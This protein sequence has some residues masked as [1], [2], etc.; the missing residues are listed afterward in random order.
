MIQEDDEYSDEN[1]FEVE[2]SNRPYDKDPVGYLNKF[3][4]KFIAQKGSEYT[5]TIFGNICRSLYIPESEYAEFIN[6]YKRATRHATFNFTEK[7]K[8]VGPLLIDI[9]FNFS[10]EHGERQYTEKTIAT[11]VRGIIKVVKKYFIVNDDDLKAIVSEKDSPCYKEKKNEYKDGMHVIIP[12]PIHVDMRYYILD[13]LKTMAEKEGWFDDI[14]YT[15]TLDDVFDKAVVMRNGWMMYG[16]KKKDGKMYNIT[17]VYDSTGNKINPS[18]YSHD[19]RIIAGSVRQFEEEDQLKFKEKYD[20]EEFAEKVEEKI[21]KSKKKK[22]KKAKTIENIVMNGMPDM[23]ALLRSPLIGKFASESDISCAKKLTKILSI[24]RTESYLDWAYVGWALINISPTL[25]DDF[26]EF[27]QRS[28][29]KYEEGCCEKLWET[30]RKEDKGLGIATLHWWAKQD[31]P[32]EYKKIIGQTINKYVLENNFGHHDDIAKVVFE[33]YKYHYKCTSIKKN[34]WFEFQGNRWVN[35]EE[36]YTLSNK[37]SDEIAME[38]GKTLIDH[39]K[40]MM[41][42][43]PNDVENYEKIEKIQKKIMSINK[44]LSNLKNEGFKRSVMSACT[45]RFYDA[46]FME[47]LDDNPNIVGFDN[48]VFDL[49]TGCFRRGT[50][51]DFLTFS[52]GYDYCEYDEN[53]P[54]IQGLTKYF[55]QVHSDK[56]IHD[57][58]LTL[59]ASYI[60]GNINDQKVIIWTGSGCHARDEKIMMHNGTVKKVQDIVHNDKLM[61]PDGRARTVQ[62]LFEG[63]SDMY[64]IKLADGIN[65]G[66]EFTVNKHHRL[67]LMYNGEPK[68][69]LNDNGGYTVTWHEIMEDIPIQFN[70]SFDSKTQYLE[71]IEKL[72]HKQNVLLHNYVI[73]VTVDDYI[74]LPPEVKQHFRCY[75]VKI[76]NLVEEKQEVYRRFLDER[77][78][79]T[80]KNHDTV[81]VNKSEVGTNKLDSFLSACHWLGYGVLSDVNETGVYVISKTP[82]DIRTYNFCVKPADRQMFYGFGLD[83]DQKYVMENMVATYNSNGKST[84][85]DLIRF[86]F[87]DYFD[88]MP[89]TVLTRKR[90]SA[91]NATPELADKAGKRFVIIQEPEHNDVVYVGYM[92]QL[93]G[94]DWVTARPLYGDPFK[95]KPQF[96]LAFTCN[97]LPTIPSTDGG[98]WRRLRVTPWEAEFVDGVPEKENQYKKD[99]GLGR[100]L[101]EWSGAFMYMLCTKYYPMYKKNGLI[102]PEKV[103]MYTNKYKK[104]SDLYYEFMCENMVI[105]KKRSDTESMASIFTTFKNWYRESY[106][107]NNP[108]KKELE[109]YFEKIELEKDG[110]N[111]HGVKF[112]GSDEFASF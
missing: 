1:V 83:G 46:K 96:K 99:L 55:K 66:T 70:E 78:Y 80:Y 7:Q 108:S 3:I 87:G 42:N 60:D 93:S 49:T 27:S 29:D 44:L 41:D 13:E 74:Q 14:P 5:H 58:I 32:E 75:R 50:P 86:A 61:G 76:N 10:H 68:A 9:D 100:K 82:K 71:H 43:N 85:V 8:T 72:K 73:P 91:G 77:T 11:L 69:V 15:N 65:G 57:Y 90:G 25:L 26:I 89:V 18:Y 110:A 48:G 12:L 17:Y 36:G 79:H 24:K 107:S 30:A 21:S 45:K 63:E 35:I 106:N 105:T 38:Y 19:E 94:G 101:K 95:F 111:V 98:T 97:K 109:A 84:T 47:K 22:S 52:C 20:T 39:T 16:S 6:I 64:T 2:Q 53:G 37:L 88:E 54:E 34:I 59:I 104:D 4:E 31:N 51:D 81:Y 92:K 103:T 33:I 56:G 102:E 67:S 112:I 28:P 40:S 62:T 23:D